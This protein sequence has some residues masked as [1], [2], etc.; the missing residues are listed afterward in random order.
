MSNR[1]LEHQTAQTPHRSRSRLAGLLLIIVAALLAYYL[2]V[3]YL[4]WQ[5][6]QQLLSERQEQ[7][8]TGQIARQVELAQA[9]IAASNYDLA[10]R[11]LEWVLVRDP[12]HSTAQQLQETAQ[13]ARQVRSEQPAPPRESITPTSTPLPSPTP[14]VIADPTSELARIDRLIAGEEWAVAATALQSFQRQFPDHER[15]RTDRLLYDTYIELGMSYIEG[16]RAELGLF[17]LNQ[18]ER[19]GD[20]PESVSDYRIWAELYTQGISFYGVN[21]D[22]A[23]FYFR[24]LCLAAPFYQNACQRLGQI[25][26]RHGDAFALLED[27]CPAQA[28]YEEA[29]RHSGSQELGRKLAEARENCLLA[30]PTPTAPIT[31]TRTITQTA[32]VDLIPWL[33]PTSIPTP[34][35]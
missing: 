17:Y 19:L 24:D 23:A 9:D 11:R 20:L 6:G 7:Q 21:W 33:P 2:L 27:W 32:P 16:E 22:A 13:T 3:V 8:F 30:T 25:L 15:S 1:S 4:G 31:D 35:P 26:T 29:Q 34:T 5:S 12:H 10:L 18:A 14:G 28:L